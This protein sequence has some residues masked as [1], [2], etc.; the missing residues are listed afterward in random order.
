MQMTGPQHFY[1]DHQGGQEIMNGKKIEIW[2]TVH[3]L[4]I[5]LRFN[6]LGQ[7]FPSHDAKELIS[8]Q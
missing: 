5:V 4:V 3:I 2:I 8:Q 1:S 7:Q 6:I